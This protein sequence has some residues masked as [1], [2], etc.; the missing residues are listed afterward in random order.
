MRKAMAL[1]LA[2]VMFAVVFSVM[3]TGVASP[4]GLIFH[5]HFDSDTPGTPPDTS[6]PGPPAG[7][8]IALSEPAGYIMVQS[9][10][11][12][13]TSQPVEVVCTGGIGSVKMYGTVAGTP[14][15]S[16]IWYASWYG[17]VQQGNYSNMFAPMVIRDSSNLILAGVAYRENGIIDFN[18]LFTGSGIGVTYTQG[19]S[20]FFE[21]TIDMDAKTTSLAMDGFP[22]PLCQNKNFY[23]TGASDLAHMN[24]EVGYT[25]YQAYAL[26][27]LKIWSDVADSSIDINPNTLNLKSKGKWIMGRIELPVQDNTTL[28]DIPTVAIVDINGVPVNIP[29]E[30][31]NCDVEEGANPGEY[32]LKCMVKFDRSA[33]QDACVPGPT[34]ITI[35]GQLTDGTTFEGSDTINVINPP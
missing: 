26:D 1:G 18:D 2:F 17:L 8:S 11:G 15:T 21:L 6:L 10:I 31:G 7:D 24:F 12:D 16:G 20:Q 30:W 33:V 13:L 14:P 4:G 32:V 23:E 28:V 34:T 29:A 35:T 22:I 5:A 25:T 9:S 19:V 27:D 3:P